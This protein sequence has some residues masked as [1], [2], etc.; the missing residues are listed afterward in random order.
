MKQEMLEPCIRMLQVILTIKSVIQQEKS[1]VILDRLY[2]HGK[3]LG[4]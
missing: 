4:W 1:K 3:I 2:I